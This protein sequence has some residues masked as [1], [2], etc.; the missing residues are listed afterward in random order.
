MRRR[1]KKTMNENL[2]WIVKLL[3]FLVAIFF[4]RLSAYLIF[5]YDMNLCLS[6]GMLSMSLTIIYIWRRWWW[7]IF[8]SPSFSAYAITV[9]MFLQTSIHQGKKS[10]I[11]RGKE[12]CYRC[13]VLFDIQGYIIGKNKKKLLCDKILENRKKS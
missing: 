7:W 8:F 12:I 5:M 13:S 3:L 4:L 1:R 11:E 9:S 10:S 6:F 2:L